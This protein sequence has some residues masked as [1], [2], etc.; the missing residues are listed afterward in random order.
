MQNVLNLGHLDF[1]FVS[2]F[3]LR[4]SNF[5][6]AEVEDFCNWLPRQRKNKDAE[7]VLFSQPAVQLGVEIH[8]FEK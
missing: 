4:I 2:N 5:P 6:I 3:V 8:D 7:A 1:G